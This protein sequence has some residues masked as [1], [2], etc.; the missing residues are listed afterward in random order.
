MAISFRDVNRPEWR[1]RS[2]PSGRRQVRFV[3]LLFGKRVAV[4]YKR[5]RGI[6][7]GLYYWHGFQ[8]ELLRTQR[9]MSNPLFETLIKRCKNDEI[10]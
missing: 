7:F 3:A 9:R 10:A 5:K 8:E 2:T 4:F 1:P 6:S